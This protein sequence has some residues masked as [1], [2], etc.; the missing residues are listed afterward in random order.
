MAR[1]R[2]L[3]FQRACAVLRRPSTTV[4]V[5][6]GGY[7]PAPAVLAQIMPSVFGWMCFAKASMLANTQTFIFACD[8]LGMLADCLST[9]SEAGSLESTSPNSMAGRLVTYIKP[10]SAQD[11]LYLL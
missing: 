6:R 8:S 9:C 4:Q 2:S 1:L 11:A 10:T 3:Y 5:V 7:R